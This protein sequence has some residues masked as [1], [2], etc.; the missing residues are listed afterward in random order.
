TALA[1]Y[2]QVGIVEIGLKPDLDRAA[3]YLHHAALF[4]GDEDAQFELV[5]MK[6]SG[7]GVPEDI[8]GAKHWLAVLS[9]RGHSGAQAF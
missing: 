8:A 7:E 3:D 6:L 4:F 1:G 9:Q 5:K 2:L